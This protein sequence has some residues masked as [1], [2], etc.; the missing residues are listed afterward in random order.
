MGG[1]DAADAGQSIMMESPMRQSLPTLG[2]AL[3]AV[4]ATATLARATDLDAFEKLIGKVAPSI[5][6]KFK[7]RVACACPPANGIMRAGYDVRPHLDE[8]LLR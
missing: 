8:H 1:D 7:P 4:I 6:G 2:F 3:L 5:T